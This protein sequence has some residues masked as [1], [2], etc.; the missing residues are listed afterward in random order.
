[1]QSIYKCCTE[2]IDPS[3]ATI[4]EGNKLVSVAACSTLTTAKICK[5]DI[6]YLIDQ[7]LGV[8]RVMRIK[9]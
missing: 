8:R 6:S 9:L 7:I 2:P 4:I 1:M 5:I 3:V